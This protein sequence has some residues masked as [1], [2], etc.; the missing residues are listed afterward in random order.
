MIAAVDSTPTPNK[1]PT[2]RPGPSTSAAE[3][4]VRQFNGKLKSLQVGDRLIRRNPLFFSRTRRLFDRLDSCSLEERI[5]WTESRL[6]VVLRRA[7]SA[8]RYGQS[9]Q[10]DQLG[11][12]PLLDKDAI[13]D[14]PDS[15]TGRGRRLAARASTSGTTGTPL[16][17]LRSLQ[18]VAVEQAA[19]DRLALAK[20]V[21]LATARVAVFRGDD[22]PE[23]A[24]DLALWTDER[25]GLRRA[26]AS[27]KLS[28]ETLPAF[29]TALDEFKPDC[30]L[31]YPTVL[32]SLCLLL[33]EHGLELSIPLTL[34]SSEVLSPSTRRLAE[35]VINTDVVDYY[36]QAERVSFAY[37]F[38]ADAYTFL[39]GYGVTELVQVGDDGE[40]E[41][42]E[43]VGTSLWNLAMPLIRYRT[44]DLIALPRASSSSLRE[45]ISYG[46]RSVAGIAGRSGDFLISPTGGRLVG[47]DHIPR[48]VDNILRLQFIQEA[49]D[50]VRI[51]ILAKAGFAD[52]DR[53]QIVANIGRKFPPDLRY[54]LEVVDSL[55][56]VGHKTPLV[57]R[58]ID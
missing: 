54:S 44:G 52:R 30:L 26:L 55:E 12:W 20:G 23:S 7:A 49:R 48:E 31:A 39:P 32:E 18:S 22:I 9:I 56:G 45:E 1:V 43:I 36:G 50:F 4:A 13:R 28:R 41:L 17:L 35:V 27:N 40:S 34:T 2:S 15:F 33:D 47:I 3:I 11:E 6:R 53:Q 8:S 57:I 29:L 42:F 19:I 14:E 37:S 5:A 25:R 10:S 46:L 21:D 51:L 24:A 16:K 58:Q 38:T